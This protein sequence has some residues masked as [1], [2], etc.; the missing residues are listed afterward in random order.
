MVAA[1]TAGVRSVDRVDASRALGREDQLTPV[2]Q[3]L[4]TGR[5]ARRLMMSL[6]IVLHLVGTG[7]TA[8]GG[9]VYSKSDGLI[10]VD[11]LNIGS[12]NAG[13]GG[14]ANSGSAIGGS[15]GCLL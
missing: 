2:R 10:N 15:G 3:P 4:L 12:G 7:G 1:P 8:N 13:K 11:A 5:L 14:Q 6:I 9:N